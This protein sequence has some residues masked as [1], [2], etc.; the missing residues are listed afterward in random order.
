MSIDHWMTF[1]TFGEQDY[2]AY[3]NKSTYSGVI[4][5]GNMAAYAPAG[6]AAFLLEKISRETSYLIDPLTHAFQHDPGLIQGTDGRPKTSIRRMADAY[7]KPVSETVGSKPIHP[8]IFNRDDVLNGFVTRCINYQNC[9]LADRMKESNAAKYLSTN[10]ELLPYAVVAPYFYMTEA[11]I[12]EWLPVNIRAAR[13]TVD[14]AEDKQRCFAA[15]VVSQGVILDD[16]LVKKI[17]DGFSDIPL[18]GFLLWIDNLDEQSAAVAE[19]T[20]TLNLARTLRNGRS[21]EVINLHGGYFSILAAGVLGNHALS[22]VS[23]GPEFGEFRSVVPVGGGIPISRY[24]VP[25]LHARIRYRDAAS[26]FREASW[27]S[28]SNTFHENV[29]GCR[30]CRS[31]LDGDAGNFVKFGEGTPKQV[32]R[33]HGLVTIDF[34]TR[35]ARERCLKHY[36]EGKLREYSAASG[37]P[38]DIL[39][40]NL[41]DGEAQFRKYMGNTGVSHLKLWRKVFGD[42]SRAE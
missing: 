31:A 8:A 18:D 21:R 28:S 7:G 9:Q 19:L 2:F 17:A 38:R 35:E 20:G 42:E 16:D 25:R 30:V 6:L 11:T 40:K 12:D 27:L 22:G 26:T 5:N 41:R 39:L 32:R 37:A 10:S 34:P 4:I 24:Y 14:N 13:M 15:V 36:L 23:H 29:C 33:R 3:P 1:S